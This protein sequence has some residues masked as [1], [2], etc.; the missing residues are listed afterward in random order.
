[1]KKKAVTCKQARDFCTCLE[2]RAI[3]KYALYGRTTTGNR[4]YSIPDGDE[5]GIFPDIYVFCYSRKYG[6]NIW[7]K[8]KIAD[9]P[10]IDKAISDFVNTGDFVLAEKAERCEFKTKHR[11]DAF[12]AKKREEFAINKELMADAPKE[13]RIPQPMYKATAYQVDSPS[14]RIDGFGAHRGGNTAPEPEKQR[15][16][17]LKVDMHKIAR[18]SEMDKVKTVTLRRELSAREVGL[19]TNGLLTQAA[20]MKTYVRVERNGDRKPFKHVIT[21]MNVNN[22]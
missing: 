16:D 8:F 15:I 22:E 11:N 10:E 21:V 14:G 2:K 1:M 18:T 9:F 17:H 6:K 20:E 19:R 5:T 12:H 13:R 3:P 4:W 7:R